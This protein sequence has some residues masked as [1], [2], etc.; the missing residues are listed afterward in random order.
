MSAHPRLPGRCA[1]ETLD[2]ATAWSRALV[3]FSGRADLGWLRLLRPGFRHC[4]VVLDTAAGWILVNP[5]AH[6][7][8]LR[9]LG[10]PAGFDLAGWYQG[11][12]LR[13]VETRPSR[14]PHSPAPWRPHTCVE[15]VKRILGIQDGFVLTPWQL[16]RHLS[17]SR[18]NSLTR[19]GQTEDDPFIPTLPASDFGPD[20]GRS[21][22]VVGELEQTKII[23]D[24]KDIEMGGFFSPSAPAASTPA[25]IVVAATDTS[26]EDATKQREAT[27][28]RNR[29]GLAGTIAT[30]ASGLLTPGTPAGKSLLGE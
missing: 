12:G 17:N 4:F 22:T 27:L 3:A 25:P 20:P 30:S 9:P 26:E 16:F 19:P 24:E 18:I 2:L 6:R 28:A 21:A 8:D 13:V 14:P 11:Q 23:L 5:M 7:T 29:R 1:A 10:L 15:T